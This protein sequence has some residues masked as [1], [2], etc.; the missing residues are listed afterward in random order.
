MSRIK[1]V[2]AGLSWT[3]IHDLVRI[4]IGF[5]S[6]PLSLNYFGKET[7]GLIAM[8]SSIN[9]YLSL[10]DLGM[11]NTNVRFFSEF[12]A[13][14]DKDKEQRLISFTTLFYLVIGLVNSVALFICAF[15]VQDIFKVTPEQAYTL[16]N[17]VFILALN[18]T[19]SWVSACLDQYLTAH[20]LID[21]IKKRSVILRLVSFCALLMA[22]WLKWGIE[23]YFFLSIFSITMI[24]PLSVYKA[25][26]VSQGLKLSPRYDK[27]MCRTVLPYALTV[28]SFSIFYFLAY[29]SRSLLLG[30][31]CGPE[32]VA[33]FTIV[34][35]IL[36]VV[37]MVTSGFTT[38]FLPMVTKMRVK[39][40]QGSLFKATNSGTKLLNIMLSL[41]VFVLALDVKEVISIYVGGGY[42]HLAK[43]VVF[44][45]LTLLLM[46]RNVMTALVY[47]E[48]KLTIVSVMGFVAMSVAFVLYFIFIP[49]YG[50]GGV[51]I[52]WL[53]HE[54]VH[55]LFYYLYFIP[56]K[57]N[58]NTTIVF[59]KS[60]LPTWILY[61][62]ITFLLS[63]LFT[64]FDLSAW[65]SCIIKGVIYVLLAFPA[66]WF[67]LLDK[68]ERSIIQGLIIKKETTNGESL[69]S[70]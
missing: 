15:F 28:F 39:N 51:F 49:K 1:K 3:F 62:F 20:E 42:E 43:W 27:E 68:E 44:A 66:T 60:V 65:P 38:V 6:V 48:R 45:L 22:I 33:E 32:I 64:F 12:I 23:I 55:T 5:V 25:K 35:T 59:V 52:G 37:S 36:S 7:Y 61:S 9:V 14:G 4:I 26:S 2:V 30:N 47:T 16:R 17:L 46:H 18:A 53:G 8:A 63:W 10:L 50:L 19:F 70:R 29:N 58:I 54:I 11:S 56:A 67:L 41:V 69:V 31:M 24:L 21:W 34:I 13:N 57:L 40:E